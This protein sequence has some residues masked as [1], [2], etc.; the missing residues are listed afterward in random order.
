MLAASLI[1]LA[2]RIRGGPRAS[3]AA[4][5]LLL[6]HPG[7]ATNWLW[8]VQ[9]AFVLPTA[10]G[11]AYLIPIAGRA[12]WPGRRQAA[13]AGL[14]MALLPLCGATGLVFVP[15]LAAWLLAAAFVEARSGR[16]GALARAATIAAATAPGMALT[17][18]YF[19]GFRRVANP[20][21]PG[22]VLD[23]IRTA[24][25]FLAGGVGMPASWA[26]PWSGAATLGL[27]AMA[28]A[29][30]GHAWAFRPVE[31]P[32]V[33]GLVAFLAAMAAM[34]AGVGW[35]RG[36]AGE[37]AGFQGRYVTMAAPFWCWLIVVTR[38]YAPPAL[39]GLVANGIFAA[40]CILLWP[41]AREGLEQGRRGRQ[42]AD[43][44]SRDIR[45]GVPP[46]RIVRR[47]TPFLHPSQDEVARLLPLLRR[48]R[49]GPFAA[50]RDDPPFRDIP[51]P[52]SPSR[53]ELA[54]WDAGTSTA[55]VTGV[56]PQITFRV[57]PPRPVAGLPHQIFAQQP[58]R[59]SGPIPAHLEAAR[60]RGIF[61]SSTLRQL[62]PAHRRRPDH[63]LGRRRGRRIPR[64]AG[65]PT[66]H[67]PHRRDRPA[68]AVTRAEADARRRAAPGEVGSG[69]GRAGQIIFFKAASSAVP[70][71]EPQPVAAS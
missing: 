53:L 31:R 29:V 37:Q 9:F 65:Q 68:G 16:A 26:W 7:H 55:Q 14:G 21:A 50:L 36:W 66:R 35:G 27:L 41:N 67:I 45:A 20:P 44:L 17:A 62:E 43:A 57:D 11:T 30:L 32:R 15:A 56:A 19:G 5:P 6:L 1:G 47:Y 24:V 23:A 34:A 10:L 22:G 51:L 40:A 58:R 52:L 59:V 8:G 49:V 64:P 18:A 13:A 61:R 42:T 63:R 60:R 28:L 39:G 3:D 70:L 69:G 48:G 25:Q 46:F 12:G 2:G 54:R 33:F 71:G 38:L 4:F